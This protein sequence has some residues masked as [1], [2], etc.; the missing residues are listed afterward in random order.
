MARILNQFLTRNSNKACHQFPDAHALIL[1]LKREDASAI[2][3]LSSQIAGS[4]FKIGK[5]FNLVDDDIEELHCDCIMIFIDKIRAGQYEYFGHKPATYVI[6]IAKRRVNHYFRK[7]NR[8][9][10]EDLDPRM[11]LV[12]EE[13]QE[14]LGQIALVQELLSRLSEKCQ[15]LIR[16]K[17]LDEHKDKEVIEQKLSQYTTVNALKNHRAQCMKKLVELGAQFHLPT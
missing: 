12:E 6:E 9:N 17:Y 5:G 3:C 14:M 7:A 8:R 10:T 13:S 11:D 16:L 15:K 2:N 1:A 4:V